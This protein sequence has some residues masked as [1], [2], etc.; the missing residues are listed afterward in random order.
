MSY[1][2]EA[3]MESL[4]EWMRRVRRDKIPELR[5]RIGDKKEGMNLREISALAVDK[6]H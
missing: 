6:I 5:S 1:C 2:S 3:G 4:K